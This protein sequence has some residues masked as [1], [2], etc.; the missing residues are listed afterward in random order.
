MYKSIPK[1][2]SIEFSILLK[3]KRMDYLEFIVAKAVFE[4]LYIE[5]DKQIQILDKYIINWKHL[6]KVFEYENR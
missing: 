3:G 5:E 6:N 2:S 1:A 4:Y